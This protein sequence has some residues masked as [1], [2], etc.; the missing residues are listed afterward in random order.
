M[1]V[2]VIQNCQPLT[3]SKPDFAKGIHQF[4]EIRRS[5]HGFR[6]RTK[7]TQIQKGLANVALSTGAGQ[8][9]ESRLAGRKVEMTVGSHLNEFVCADDV[10]FQ[11]HNEMQ[12]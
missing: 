1:R 11:W 7:R 10:K 12:L 6:S 9:G 2:S 5:E 8:S 3:V 4:C